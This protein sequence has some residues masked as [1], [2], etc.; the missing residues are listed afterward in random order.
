MIGCSLCRLQVWPAVER[1][2]APGSGCPSGSSG[3]GKEGGPDGR[4][5]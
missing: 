2:D 1:V 5:Y 3:E 4:S